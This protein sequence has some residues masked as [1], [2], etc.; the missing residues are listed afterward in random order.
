MHTVPCGVLCCKENQVYNEV[1]L[2]CDHK[3]G[4]HS[5]C[6]VAPQMGM[7]LHAKPGAMVSSMVKG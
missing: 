6:L 1:K 7:S 4:V 2:I 3:L 5:Q